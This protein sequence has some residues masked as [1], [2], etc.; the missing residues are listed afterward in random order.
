MKQL[1]TSFLIFIM[2]FIPLLSHAQINLEEIYEPREYISDEGDTLR[3]RVMFPNEFEENKTYPL[4]LFL[5]GAGER[6]N[7]NTAQL[8]WGVDA[9][10]AED[11]RKDHP[12]IVIAP[13]A[14]EGTFW[15]NLNWRDEGAG[16]MEEPALP[17]KLTHELVLK[18]A[19]EYPVDENRLYITGLS[20]GGFGTWDLITRHPGLFAAAMPICGGG[21]PSKA[22]RI[23]ELPI[24]NFH[25]ALDTIVPPR[26]SRDMIRA[27]RKAGGSPGYTE[28]PGVG[29]FSWIPAYNDRFVL[30][31]L[32]GQ[33]R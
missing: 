7:D 27:I 28:Y 23:A 33:S 10:A 25:G 21:D 31:W 15:A 19:V 13:Q 5:H 29:H 1:S 26:L 6:G 17:L 11:F 9:F 30:D 4:L 2:M 16:L 22:D 8:T 32:F 18:M 14:P 20:M 24:W 12:A 3:Y